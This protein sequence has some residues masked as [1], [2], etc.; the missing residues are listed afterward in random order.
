MSENIKIV[1]DIFE[2]YGVPYEI[3]ADGILVLK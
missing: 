1:V 3:R 2:K